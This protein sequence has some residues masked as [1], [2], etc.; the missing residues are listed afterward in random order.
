MNHRRNDPNLYRLLRLV[1]RPF[2]YQVLGLEHVVSGRP[3]LYA[4]NH[5]GSIGPVATLLSVPAHF[6]PWVIADMADPQRAARYLY[7]DFVEPVWKLRGR[8]GMAV[9]FL[10][11]RISLALIRGLEGVAVDRADARIVVAFRRSLGHLRRG[12]AILV[13]PEDGKLSADPITGLRPFHCNFI[14][15]GYLFER[16]TGRPL[17]IHPLAIHAGS[18]RIAIGPALYFADHNDRRGEIARLCG[19][20]RAQVADLYRRL[21]ETPAAPPG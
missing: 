20:L 17:P 18:R 8:A 5:L 15:L 11:S 21:D 1:G 2:R 6:H 10:V 3:A 12:E 14:G 4:G 9:A 19:T 13:F 16:E 7:H